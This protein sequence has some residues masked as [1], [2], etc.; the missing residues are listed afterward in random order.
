MVAG[1]Q[2]IEDNR[3]RRAAILALG[4][5]LSACASDT[6]G[7][8]AAAPT[9]V[10]EEV[11]LA[12]DPAALHG[13]FIRPAGKGPFP[14]VVIHA[15]SGPTDRNGNQP[16]VENNSL[17]MI[18][19][20]LAE[21][22]VASLRIDKRG[23][24]A[25][26]GAMI[27][28]V[29]LRFE[30]YADDLV[31]WAQLIDARVDTSDVALLGHSEGG[32]IS[33]LAAQRFSPSHVVLVATPGRRGSDVIRE[34]LEGRLPPDLAAKSEEILTALENGETVDDAPPQLAALFRPS[35]QPYLAS[36][37]RYDPAEEL[38]KVDA[39]VLILQGTTDI[40]IPVSD[41]ERLA[42]AHD[43]ARLVVIEGMNHVLK[44]APADP[45]ANAAVYN[46]PDLPLSNGVIEAVATFLTE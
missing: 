24:G 18:A 15:G 36:W 39:P 12:A 28:E 41:A 20:G 29:D 3:L 23:I 44:D 40:Q 37:F 32:G 19:H 11:V 31:A 6:L 8:D 7:R 26:A 14:V 21:R 42:G 27:A 17:K 9:I 13:S 22:G 1:E 16:G 30:T 43:N 2:K 5:V 10:E 34:Q 33:I 45:A 35:V 4:F 25:S 38:K 46:Q